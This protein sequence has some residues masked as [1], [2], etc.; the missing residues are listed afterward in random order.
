M[1]RSREKSPDSKKNSACCGIWS[2]GRDRKCVR[3]GAAWYRKKNERIPSVC[4][5]S[6]PDSVEQGN[7]AAGFL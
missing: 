6:R 3:T 2:K 7:D 5:C 1:D 4:G